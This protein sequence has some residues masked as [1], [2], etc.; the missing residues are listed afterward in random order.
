MKKHE[1]QEYRT[2][3]IT[4][5]HVY[6][7]KITEIEVRNLSKPEGTIDMRTKWAIKRDSKGH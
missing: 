3:K 4:E 5:M 1:K 2:Y 6:G 7:N